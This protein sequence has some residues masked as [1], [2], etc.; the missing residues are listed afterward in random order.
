MAKVFI[1]DYEIENIA[2]A[3]R[4]KINSTQKMLPGSMPAQIRN[5]TS[6]NVDTMGIDQGVI[7]EANRV[8]NS[9]NNKKSANSITFIA[10]SDMHEMG[11]S[12][13]G[14]QSIIDAYR[15]ANA[16]AGQGAELIAKKVRPDFFAN[17]GDL[18]WGLQSYTIH[19]M[20]QSITNARVKTGTLE[21]LTKYFATP[22]NHDI[23]YRAGS[24]DENLVKAMIGNYQ[25]IDFESKKIRVIVANTSDISDGTDRI[26]GVSGEQLQWFSEALDLSSKSNASSWGILIFS[27]HPLDWN[28][29]TMPLANCVASYLNGA[30]YSVTH[31]GITVSKNYSGKNS[32]T[33]I[34]TFHGHV[35][36]FKV[37]NLSTTTED[38]PVKR[39]AIPNACNGR[40]NEYGRDGNLTF[41]EPAADTCPSGKERKSTIAGQDT[42]FCVVTIDLTQKIIYADC[43]GSLG[44]IAPGGHAGYDRIISYGTQVVNAYTIKSNLI[45]ASID[46]TLSSILEGNPYSASILPDVNYKID[47]VIVTMGGVDITSDAYDGKGNIAIS[48]V[49]GDIIITVTTKSSIVYNVTNL[50]TT[51]QEQ[52]S[53]NVY[54][55][56]GVGYKNGVYASE[57][58]DGTDA[59][60]VATG[61]IPYSWK[62]S[63]VIYVRGAK[64]T[65]NSHVRFYGY[66]SN[67]TSLTD[68]TYVNGSNISVHFNVEEIESG[69]YYKLTP[70]KTLDNIAYIRISLIG[71]GENLIITV[72][73]EIIPDSPIIINS[74]PQNVSVDVGT[75]V[76]FSVSASSKNGEEL[77]YKWQVSDN[78][79][80]SWSNIEHT[81][82]NT[83]TIQALHENMHGTLLRCIIQD[84]SGN[85]VVTESAKL[86]INGVVD[87]TNLVT[88][89]VATDGET[90]FNVSGY[91]NG[92]YASAEHYRTDSSS[93]ACV[94]T[95]FI[96]FGTTTQSIYVKG[97]E[98]Q[99][100]NYCRIRFF[101]P[102]KLGTS[103]VAYSL[104]GAPSNE[105]ESISKLF[106]M[107]TLGDKY[108]KLTLIESMRSYINNYW[109]CMSLIG[110][111]ENLIITHDEVI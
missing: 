54:N 8:A 104:D 65:N 66:L 97:A 101:N 79:G 106:T 52:G 20:A 26:E 36:C 39:I 35:H 83:Y 46:N 34:G 41:G 32:A 86:S 40:N 72:N 92:V 102:Q 59:S 47:T 81:N 7:D 50:V 84:V 55:G 96:N 109:Y 80:S 69:T 5:I 31:D 78:Q 9:I 58:G 43:F 33:I 49:T 13:H 111:G 45:N 73:E 70:I 42:A 68:N 28:A 77:S 38:N 108:Y 99:D 75:V 107:E 105:N 76:D 1:E 61:W 64:V 2:D 67:K 91:M 89:S 98:W 17:L 30:T 14:T 103:E 4:E 110:T 62:P 21:R 27:H 48:K 22:G 63:N 37:S 24:F 57:T 44:D 88:T 19:D 3:I 71:T 85:I 18:A 53:T 94:T 6:G 87:Y 29:N 93:S 12:D 82:S 10:I 51:S 90:V 16:H 15:L 100:T 23:G 60:C 74:H 25:Y 95:G 11:D 56:V